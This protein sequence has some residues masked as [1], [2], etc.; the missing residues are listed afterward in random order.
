MLLVVFVGIV[1]LVMI[2]I[3]GRKRRKEIK[4]LL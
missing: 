2:Y 3:Y 1:V 4:W